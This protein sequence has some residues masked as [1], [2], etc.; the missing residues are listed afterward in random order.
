M[1]GK[2]PSSGTIKYVVGGSVIL[3]LGALAFL[4]HKSYPGFF[5]FSREGIEPVPGARANADKAEAK[6]A[7]DAIALG[8]GPVEASAKEAKAYGGSVRARA[9]DSDTPLDKINA[10]LGSSS[11]R[12]RPG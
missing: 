12:N 6:D 2:A 1:L 11:P 3:G 5:K 7:V 8:K 4:Y 10:V 9:V